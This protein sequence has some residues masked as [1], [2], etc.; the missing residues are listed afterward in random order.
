MKHIF[1]INPNAGKGHAYNSVMPKLNEALESRNIDYVVY[2]SKSSEDTS[3]YCRKW[4]ES[5]EYVRIY[6]CGGDGT[7]Y[8]V[9]NAIYGYDNVEFA[10]IPLG[11]GNDFIRMFG[12]KEQFADIGAQIDGTTVKIDA[13]RCG[14]RIAVNQCSM[15]LDAEVCA[16]QSDFKKIPWLTGESA[17]M[18]SLLYCLWNKRRNKFSVV[19]DDGEPLDGEFLLAVCLNGRYYGGG[20]MAGPYAVPDDGLLDFCII[21][22]MSIPKFLPRISQYK[23][24]KHYKWC[25]TN[26]IRGRK[27]TVRSEIPAAVNV[28]GETDMAKEVTFE[29]LPGAF[30]FVIPASSSYIEDR[31]SGLVSDKIG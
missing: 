13:I 23:N 7:V 25:E 20:F 5:G 22:T 4:A 19:A 11:S 17:Y 31:K 9:V 2:V 3:D 26:Y 14:E 21:R 10:A 8:D 29:V 16:K 15:G 30:N 12:T 1:I 18:A 27:L 24:G 6:A 28:D